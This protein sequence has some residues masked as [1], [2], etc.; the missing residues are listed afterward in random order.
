MSDDDYRPRA[1]STIGAV[2]ML[3]GGVVTGAPSLA[4]SL[5]PN[6]LGGPDIGLGSIVLM[7]S[8]RPSP[9]C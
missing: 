4:N 9:D 3:V 1:R 7:A 8:H 5:Y 6:R 2:L